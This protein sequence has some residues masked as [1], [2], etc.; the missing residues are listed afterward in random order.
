[1]FDVASTA[2][3]PRRQDKSTEAIS[4]SLARTN[5]LADDTRDRFDE[6]KK[7]VTSPCPSGETYADVATSFDARNSFVA[8]LR[9][10]SM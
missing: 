3:R 2:L 6:R 9:V 8:L 10:R 1:M 4:R 7:E 5:E